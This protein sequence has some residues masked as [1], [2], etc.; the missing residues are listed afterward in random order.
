M[1][2]FATYTWTWDI[3]IY[4]EELYRL[5]MSIPER[6]NFVPATRVDLDE[7]HA[8]GSEAYPGI[9]VDSSSL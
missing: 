8:R 3:E 1:D 4:L 6:L 2:D 7:Q 9:R 5:N